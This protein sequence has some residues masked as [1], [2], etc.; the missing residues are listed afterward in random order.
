M[1]IASNRLFVGFSV[2]F[3]F[4]FGRFLRIL[5]IQFH[6]FVNEDS[7]ISSFLIWMPFIYL[8]DL[9]I[10]CLINLSRTSRAMLN[11]NDKSRV[12]LLPGFLK[13]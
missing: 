11:K 13:G 3:C 4:V 6:L 8:I 5:C 7:F 10:D 9:L 1:F 2:L 12:G